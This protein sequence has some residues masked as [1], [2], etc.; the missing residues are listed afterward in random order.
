[1]GDKDDALRSLV[2][3]LGTYETISEIKE[4]RYFNTLVH[5]FNQLGRS[6]KVRFLEEYVDGQNLAAGY[7]GFIEVENSLYNGE[8]EFSFKLSN[9]VRH[10]FSRSNELKRLL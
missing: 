6:E 8:R 4:S 1:M 10:K 3:F 7:L 9:W 2:H 5:Y